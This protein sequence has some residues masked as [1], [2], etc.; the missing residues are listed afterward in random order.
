MINWLS[1]LL[2]SF[3]RPQPAAQDPIPANTQEERD[4]FQEGD[5]IKYN[6]IKKYR[7]R[8]RN[9]YLK[10]KAPEKGCIYIY[11]II[12]ENGKYLFKIGATGGLYARGKQHVD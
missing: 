6:T 4:E 7:N 2:P 9:E 10:L 1:S 3:L 5:I 12:D 11:Y 8:N